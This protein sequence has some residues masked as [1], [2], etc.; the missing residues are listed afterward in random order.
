MSAKKD[1]RH[2]AVM[3]AKQIQD[4]RFNQFGKVQQKKPSHK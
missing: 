1:A 4:Q 3:K 2:S